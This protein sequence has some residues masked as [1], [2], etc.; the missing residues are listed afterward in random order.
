MRRIRLRPEI[1]L[2]TVAAFFTRL[3]QL[4]S[5][6]AIIFDE[7]YFKA[8]AAHYLD[9]RYF[10]DV[11]PPLGKL[12]LAGW[13]Q[14]LNLSPE[15]MLQG[16][17]VSMRIL[18]AVA[19]ALL[20]PL[21]WLVVRRLGVGRP[22]AAL[23]ALLVLADNA[24]TVESRLI[25][26]D[27]LLLLA[28]IGALYA[29]L[30]AHA[31]QGRARFAW[32]LTAAIGAGSAVCI[33]WTGANA[34]AII[35]VV[36]LWGLRGSGLP[37]LRRIGEGATLIAIPLMLYAASFWA[38]FALLPQSG[39]GDAFMS[40]RYQSTLVGNPAYDPAV[41]LDFWQ[42]F[43]ELNT[44]M[45]TANQTLTADHPYGSR[46]YTWP[47]QQ[48]P[49]YYWQGTTAEDGTQGNIYLLGNPVVW[50]GILV[51]LISGLVVLG[52][53][54]HLRPATPRI[55]ALLALAY[56]INLVPFIGITRVMFLYHYLFSFIYS[57]VLTAVVWDEVL[58][59]HRRHQRRIAAGLI[60]VGAMVVAGYI[61]FAPLSYGTPLTP[62]EIQSRMWLPS[63]R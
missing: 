19:G 15:T 30:R 27:P 46:W 10:F 4:F 25:V 60:G 58:H 35:G 20:V 36:W 22:I 51:T 13:A 1:I 12:L 21:V 3:W 2:L 32:V 8:F 42:K 34:L 26:M 40:A 57:I 7:I 6:D 62:Q 44:R 53:R 38:H 50:W 43:V 61:I 28:G 18:P 55:L 11:H 37:I 33:K 31:S 16:S 54:R 5:P 48:R 56:L 63:W 49:V 29:I 24:L 59:V 14:L 9:G 39:E 45:Y 23:A 17:A 47:I 52:I 41:R